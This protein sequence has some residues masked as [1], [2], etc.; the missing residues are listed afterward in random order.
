MNNV[1]N[2]NEIY[3]NNIFVPYRICPLGAHTDHQL[4]IVTGFAIDKGITL[5]YNR[6]LDGSFNVHSCDFEG[7]ISFSYNKMPKKSGTWHD[8]LIGSILA[9]KEDY[10]LKKWI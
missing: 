3:K 6:T 7:D 9:L 2:T 8:Y 10:Q 5:K 4:G 1:N